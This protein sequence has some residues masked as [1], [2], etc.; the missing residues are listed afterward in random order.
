MTSVV[1][2][3]AAIEA[4]LA[5][6]AAASGLL[7]ATSGGPDSMAL[8]RLVASWA[9]R[10]AQPPIYSATVDH[11]LRAGSRA[12]AETVGAWAGALGIA[13]SLLTWEGEKP[14][15]RIQERAR[16]ARY[17]LLAAH[18]E[19]IGADVLLTAHHA[20]DQ[21][22]TV[23]FRLLR[24]SSLAG[25]AGMAGV[26]RRD[27]L[28]HIRPLLACRKADLVAVCEAAGQPFLRDP[29][30]EDPRYART[31]MRRLA[32]HLAENGFGRAAVLRL[33]GRLARAEA[34]LAEQTRLA[35]AGLPAERTRE[36]FAVEGRELAGLADEILLRLLLGEVA[37]IGQSTHP[38]RLERAE[39]LLAR[40]KPALRRGG[41]FAGT[42]GGALIRFADGRLR[43]EP[44][45]SRRTSPAQ[46][47]PAAG[48]PERKIGSCS[49]ENGPFPWQG[50]P[51]SLN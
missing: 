19:E 38:P 14:V 36:S 5:P 43:I 25:L 48:L 3:G 16:A 41:T 7:V 8:L 12:E 18:A 44:E 6:F 23:L 13:H 15:T 17:A 50:T 42:L 21:V 45:K 40:L 39:A 11:G 20:D 47:W 49:R 22:E 46:L 30:N 1:D 4:G 9:A 27:G 2:P 28:C 31:R 29:S 10:R 34:A 51:S 32:A 24:G 33:A 26:T 35:E 37:R